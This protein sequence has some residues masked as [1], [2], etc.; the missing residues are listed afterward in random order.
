MGAAHNRAYRAQVDVPAPLGDVMGVTYV[1][2]ELRT[3]AAHFTYA[4]HLP[5]QEFNRLG[6]E[7]SKPVVLRFFKNLPQPKG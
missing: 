1:V 2:S 5:L 4:C 7:A 3:F 6:F